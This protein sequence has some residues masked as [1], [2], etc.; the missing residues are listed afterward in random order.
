MDAPRR[1]LLRRLL[2][3]GALLALGTLAL[4]WLDYLR[5]ARLHAGGVYTFLLALGFLAL[6]VFVGARAFARRPPAI[7]REPG[8]PQAQATLGISE[9][10]RVVL[11]QLAAGGSNK[12]IAQQLGISPNT[13]KTHV[14]R[15]F[16]K[17][18]ARRRT[19]AIQRARELGLLP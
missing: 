5:V 4:A 17:L 10:E 11:E 9:R 14:A 19:E 16:E 7:T 2:G 8:N 15:L 13:V 6:G 3:Y 1:A 18:G 12:E